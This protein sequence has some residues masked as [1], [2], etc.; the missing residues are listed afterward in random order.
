[1]SDTL[2]SLARAW[3]EDVEERPTL[4]D[5]DEALR[6]HRDLTHLRADGAAVSAGSSDS[7]CWA[8]AEASVPEACP[9]SQR[10]HCE[11]AT[12]GVSAGDEGTQT[13]SSSSPHD[14]MV[15]G[16]KH[17]AALRDL[18]YALLGEV[19]GGV[20]RELLRAAAGGRRSQRATGATAGFKARKLAIRTQG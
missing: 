8:T 5:L 3:D 4:R 20:S 7:E 17:E 11:E 6:H 14:R 13:E 15:C 12:D 10:W 2:E 16:H 1:M 9:R 18:V 19:L